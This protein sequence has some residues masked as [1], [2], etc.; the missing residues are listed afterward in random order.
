VILCLVYGKRNDYFLDKEKI[1]ALVVLG[2]RRIP[3]RS[4]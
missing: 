1:F 3:W 2:R 4:F